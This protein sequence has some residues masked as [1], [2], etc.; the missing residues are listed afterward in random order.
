MVCHTFCYLGLLGLLY[1]QHII[2]YL[3]YFMF[4]HAPSESLL[5]NSSPDFF[6]HNLNLNCLQDELH[7]L[8]FQVQVFLHILIYLQTPLTYDTVNYN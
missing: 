4:K 1:Q 8:H 3:L 6:L 7:H 5:H 2:I